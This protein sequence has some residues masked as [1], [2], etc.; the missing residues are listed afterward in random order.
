MNQ[1]TAARFGL[2]AVFAVTGAAK[3]T[4]SREQLEPQMSWVKDAS[5]G[6]VKTIG[7]LEVAGATGLVLPEALGMPPVLTPLA[8]AGLGLTMVGA[9]ITHVRIGEPQRIPI[10]V[11]LLGLAAYTVRTSR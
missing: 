6:Q 9:A 1:E 7:P 3:L 10:N 2:A 8:A 5:D 4:L 11:A